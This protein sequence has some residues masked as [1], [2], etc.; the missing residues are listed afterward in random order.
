[1]KPAKRCGSPTRL[2]AEPAPGLDGL[3]KDR[4]SL[5]LPP[6][7]PNAWL[8]YDIIRR[9][10]DD[11]E[12][13]ESVLEVGAGQG[14]MGV[15]LA[16]RYRYVG[17]EPDPH[18]FAKARERLAATATG[19]VLLGDSSSYEPCDTF[20]LVCAFEVLE[21]IE[22]DAGALRDW[23]RCLRQ[24][25]WLLIS[26]PAFQSHWGPTDVMAGHYR[27]YEPEGLASLLR[28][29]GF[30][31]PLVR[32]YG[33]PLGYVLEVG[34]NIIARRYLGAESLAESTARSGRLLQ[35]PDFL[36]WLTQGGTAPFRLVQR[37]FART[38]LGTGLVA[39]ARRT[40]RT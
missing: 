8:R 27:R 21:H 5:R 28:S 34:R 33:F 32:M 11:L 4:S 29:T 3:Q 19:T 37:G 15:R 13:V 6:L 40:A 16:R 18:S 1:M 23:G 30:G 2:A 35:P 12:D 14:A 25:G 22:D 36:G 31:E 24:G 10:L 39:L 38:R 9:I 7:T 20:D 26:A 17:L